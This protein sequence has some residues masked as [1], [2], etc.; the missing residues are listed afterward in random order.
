MQGVSAGPDGGY[1]PLGAG[2]DGEVTDTGRRSDAD[3]SDQGPGRDEPI[4]DTVQALSEWWMF[5]IE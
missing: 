1:R 2:Q 5:E 3:G 4:R